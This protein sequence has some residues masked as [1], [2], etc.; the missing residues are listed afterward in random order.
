MLK[1]FNRARGAHK[2]III[3]FALLMGASLV[4]FYAPGGNQVNANPATNTEVLAEVGGDEITVADLYRQKQSYQ[5]RFGGQF[6]LAQ[7][8]LNDKSMLDGLVRSK[9][10]AQEA[11]RLSLGTSDAEVN[12]AVH[13]QFVDEGGKFIGVDKY[14]ERVGRLYGSPDRF[15]RELRESIAADK[16]R[17]F[18][19]AGVSVSEEEVRDDFKR[20]NSSFDLTYVPVVADKLAAAV[21]PSE[22]ELQKYYAENKDSFRYLEPQKKIR[23]LFINQE[24]V[25]EKLDIPDADLRAAYDA[26]KPEHKQAG[27]R[28]QQIVLKVA[29]QDLDQQVLAKATKLAQDMRG[30]DSTVANVTEEK[31]AEVARGNSEDPATATKGGWLPAPVRRDPNRKNDILQATLDMQEGQVS[32]PVFTA[33]AYYIFRRGPSVPKS[34]EETKRELVVSQRNTRAYKAASDIAARAVARLKE[35]RDFQKVAGEF[36]S[37]AN[38]NAADMVK[39]TAFVKP[40]DTVPDIGS[41]PQFEDAIR[42]LEN[43]NDIGDRVSVKNGFAVPMLVEK[44]EPRIPDFAEVRDEVVR[45]AKQARAQSQLE[46]TARELASNNS[47]ADALKAAAEKLGLEVKTTES[48]KLGSP[49]EGAGTSAA[50]DDAIYN[51]KEGEVAK[52]PVKLGDSWVVLAATKRT[53][54]DL[55]E[56]AKQRDQLTQGLLTTRRNDVFE[57]YVNAARA[58][59]ERDGKVKI[60]ED[61]LARN[62]DQDEAAAPPPP[63]RGGIPGQ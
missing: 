46:Q 26:L 37:E 52:T 5:Q 6:S 31:F 18:V 4:L 34:F 50:A 29:R 45:R 33:G 21:Q 32:D 61:V 55:A 42:P 30:P 51:L 2:Y 57:D 1:Q 63:F 54:A 48:Y 10:I 62:A 35:T 28:A 3:F 7:L 44:R 22:E 60:Y 25:G 13:E 38:M 9:I 17:A 16:L 19:T 41:S 59:L 8:G 27:V 14:R 40:G 15:E 58:R 53:E 24:K 47:G 12:K 56:F 20:K 36:A 23:Y 49:L 39:E 43:A 11:A